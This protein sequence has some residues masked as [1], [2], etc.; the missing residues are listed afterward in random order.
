[1]RADPAEALGRIVSVLV[2]HSVRRPWA[3]VLLSLGVTLAAL[4][5]VLGRFAL[6]SDV[7]RLFP[8]DIP[9]RVAERQMEQAFP[10]R[11]DVVVAVLDAATPAAADAAAEALA[12]ALRAKPALFRT[13]RRPDG[14]PF[15]RRHALL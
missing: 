3:T 13:V 10:Q 9:W 2:G 8:P 6:D 12:G 14:G 5:L 7:T 4:W 11:M 1:M 15:W